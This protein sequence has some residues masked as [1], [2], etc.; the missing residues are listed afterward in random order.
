VV[1]EGALEAFVLELVWTFF[2][3]GTKMIGAI[4]ARLLVYRLVV[5]YRPAIELSM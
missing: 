3:P 5:V 4:S 2:V 1:S